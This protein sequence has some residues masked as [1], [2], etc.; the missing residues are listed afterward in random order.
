MNVKKAIAI[1]LAAIALSLLIIGTVQVLS[2]HKGEAH[3]AAAT[4]AI[5]NLSFTCDIA[6][7]N[8]DISSSALSNGMLAIKAHDLNGARHKVMVSKDGKSHAYDVSNGTFLFPLPFGD[9]KYSLK[10]FENLHD[11]EYELMSQADVES[12]NEENAYLTSNSLF[13]Y[14]GDAIPEDTVSILESSSYDPNMICEYAE[15]KLSYDSEKARKIAN[16]PFR[17]VNG[18]KSLSLNSGVCSDYCAIACMMMRMKGI[19]CKISVGHCSA[20]ESL[21]CWITYLQDGEW[22]V[23]D[24]TMRDSN[25]GYEESSQTY[26]EL[27]SF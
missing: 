25:V 24:P 20:S 21:H 27:Y 12:S 17:G 3:A 11:D 19:P 1:P 9:G 18:D 6:G 10:L 15:S 23:M 13:S 22:I 14:S 8:I 4:P 2:S 16:E 7:D 26:E 5:S